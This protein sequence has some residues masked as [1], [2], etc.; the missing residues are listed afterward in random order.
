MYTLTAYN[1]DDSRTG[2]ETHTG[3][4]E[5][6]RD[7]LIKQRDPRL[8]DGMAID[9]KDQIEAVYPQDGDE[10]TTKPRPVTVEL[11]IDLAG[12][13]YDTLDINV[14]ETRQAQ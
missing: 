2:T 8:L 11:L 10:Q 5:E 7:A 6:I 9:W 1:V 12:D 13:I 4:L 3:T 14:K